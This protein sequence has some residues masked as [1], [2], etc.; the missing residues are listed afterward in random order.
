MSQ[1]I[2]C[3]LA[4]I[5]GG[6]GGLSLAAVASQLSLKVVLIE[7]GL[8][9]GDCLNYGCVPSKSLLAIAKQFYSLQKAKHSCL[10]FKEL[11]I[12]FPKVMQ[13][14]HGVIATIAVNDSIERFEALGTQV[15]KAKA[16]FLNSDSLLAGEYTI[17]ARRYVIATGSRAFIP[18]IPGLDEVA[19]FTNETI[20]DLQEQPSH[21]IVIGGGAIGSELGQAFAMLGSKVSI[22][23]GATILANDDVD[24]VAILRN[25]LELM[26]IMIYEQ[27]QV[28]RV[29]IHSDKSITVHVERNGEHIAITGSHLLIATGRQANVTGLNLE[30]AGVRYSKTIEV[31]S[32]MQTTC[33]KIYAIGDV[34]GPYQ[35]THMANYQAGIALRNI[36]FKIPTSADYRTVPWVTYTEPEIAHV[37]TR[38]KDIQ[39]KNTIIITE[40][41][42]EENDRAQIEGSIT[43]KIKVIT[44]K[45]GKILGVTIVGSHA[46]E[47]ILPWVMAIREGKTLRAFTDVIVPYPTLSEI[48][49]RVAGEF[50]KST[51]FSPLVRWLVSWLK[52]LG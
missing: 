48:S 8:M 15:I 13:Q 50:Y 23:E 6:A 46:G 42:F 4:I 1:Q 38:I 19:Y 27:A 40:W 18:P 20:F 25:Q 39:D 7:S 44:N 14:V 26:N 49:K 5:G 3:D 30:Q 10:S 43:G 45:K 17:Q 35:F 11:S 41:S 9:G 47:L 22:L 12:D 16:Q 51:L 32:H 28:Q 29:E 21:L 52:K 24:C 34:V 33:K 37:G 36:V 2:V 31:N